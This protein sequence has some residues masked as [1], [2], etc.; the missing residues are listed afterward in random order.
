MQRNTS[1]SKMHLKFTSVLSW[2]QILNL[3]MI[4]HV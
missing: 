4:L 2:P 3:V 1:A